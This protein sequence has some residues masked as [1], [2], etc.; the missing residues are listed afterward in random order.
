M[1]VPRLGLDAPFFLPVARPLPHEDD[2]A[3]RRAE[4]S[5]LVLGISH[6]VN[7][8]L[9]LKSRLKSDGVAA[10]VVKKTFW[11]HISLAGSAEVDLCRLRG[12]P[13]VGLLV[14]VF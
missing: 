5:A 10:V 3:P 14:S 8:S 13:S 11:G 7:K 6:C 4:D 12:K 2:Q 1:I 9:L